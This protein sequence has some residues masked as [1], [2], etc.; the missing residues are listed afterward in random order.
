MVGSFKL[1]LPPSMMRMDRL[2]SAR[3]SLPPMI[4]A[5]VPPGKRFSYP[6]RMRKRE[7]KNTSSNDNVILLGLFRS[8]HD[9]K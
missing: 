6:P 5:A 7:F 4:H 8:R 1:F 3:A 9:C 2:G